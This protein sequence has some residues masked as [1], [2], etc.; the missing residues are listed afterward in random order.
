M[1]HNF[2]ADVSWSAETDTQGTRLQSTSLPSHRCTR[3]EGERK[4]AHTN[5][6]TKRMIKK[7]NQW[8]VETPKKGITQILFTFRR[9]HR[10]LGLPFLNVFTHRRGIHT[11]FGLSNQNRTS[12]AITALQPFSPHSSVRP[13]TERK[14]N[15]Q[16]VKNFNQNK[17]QKSESVRPPNNMA[18]I[19]F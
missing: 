6:L 12:S 2:F 13:K 10:V 1:L 17:I 16:K 4:D 19:P 9:T 15:V 14:K 3:H 18:F 7:D 8:L 11:V 5:I